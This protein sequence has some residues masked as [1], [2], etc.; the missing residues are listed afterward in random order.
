MLEGLDV[1][2]VSLTQVL[3]QTL[4][5]RFDA[6]FFKK[7]YLLDDKNLMARKLNKLSEVSLKIDVGFVGAMTEH[8]RDEG[9]V[10]LQTKNISSF[11]IADN[12]LIKITPT[13]HKTLKKS[14]INFEDILIARSGSFGKAAIY[15]EKEVINSSDIIIIQAKKE[16]INPYYLT[17]FLNSTLGVNQMVRFASGGLQGHVNLTILE[18]LK[19]PILDSKFQV[20][21]EVV[22][23]DAYLKLQQAKLKYAQAEQTLLEAVGLADFK[24]S[25]QN[26]NIKTFAQSFGISG[27]LDAE[28]YQPKYDEILFALRKNNFDTLQNLAQIQKGVQARSED[29]NKGVL[30]ASIKDC[31]DYSISTIERTNQQDIVT[32]EPNSIVFAIT[33]ATIGKVAINNTNEMIAISGDL[34]GIKSKQISPFYLIAILASPLIQTLCKK[35]ITG[36]TNG[37]LSIQAFSNYPI[38]IVALEKQTQIADFVQQSFTLKA[39][40]EHLLNVAKRA[41][42]IAIETN[43]QT[44]VAYINEQ[45]GEK[46]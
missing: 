33:G 4:S 17:S 16:N 1:S 43:E 25:T 19:V 40:S 18:E 14:Q 32:V 9:V 38:P 24:P 23:Q 26:T 31:N 35:D 5:L 45:T 29:E 30:Y 34:I 15:L 37:H 36:A 21:I 27:R 12:E 8:Y 46:P 20:N 42:E 6:E 44:A 13:F 28:Y 10:L 7:Q 3:N 11:F 41:V 22:M 39:Q 2:E